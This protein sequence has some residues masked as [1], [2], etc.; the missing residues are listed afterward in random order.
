MSLHRPVGASFNAS[1]AH[2]T[3]TYLER[4]W[5]G[6]FEN[7]SH[8]ALK[9]AL[10]L[11]IWHEV[12]FFGRFL[13]YY[14]MDQIPF[15]KKWKIQEAKENTPEMYWK[16]VKSVIQSQLFVQLPMML[17]F[18][19]TATWLGMRFLE[20]PF[21]SWTTIALS[22]LFCLAVEDCYHYFAHRLMHHGPFY[23]YIHKLHH[24]FQ[25]PFGIAAEYAHPIEVLVV[26]QGFFL[27]PVALLAMGVDM[28]VLTMAVWLAVRLIETVDVHAGYDFP[29][30]IHKILPFWGGADFHDYHHMAFVGNYSSSF[31]WWDWLFG[32]DA[33]YNVW[34]AKQQ[35]MARSKQAV[36]QD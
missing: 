16:C 19:P 6:L 11:F 25:A 30:S 32:T 15:F 35:E 3:P 28:H 18:H 17:L 33:A 27:G 13:P 1:S 36:K 2:Y 14:I 24:E 34:K 22:C 5:V 12:V 29:W 21:P 8:P 10:V 26:G 23:K 9:L 4:Q 7:A 20:V 31:R